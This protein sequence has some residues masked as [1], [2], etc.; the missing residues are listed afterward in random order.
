MGIFSKYKDTYIDGNRDETV[1]IGKARKIDCFS[2]FTGIE[3]HVYE[4]ENKQVIK[5]HY[6]YRLFDIIREP[7]IEEF[8]SIEAYKE[9]RKKKVINLADV[10]K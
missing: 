5:V 6:E 4:L 9:S 10:K 1:F 2:T 3:Y 8:E 7:M